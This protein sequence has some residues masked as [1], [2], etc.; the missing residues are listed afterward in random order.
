M[1][2]LHKLS[3][4]K[5]DW[6]KS[7]IPFNYYI[8]GTDLHG[9]DCIDCECGLYRDLATQLHMPYRMASTYGRFGV[10]GIRTNPDVIGYVATN[11]IT[12]GISPSKWPKRGEIS[13]L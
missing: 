10:A 2:T 4:F 6:A 7:L 1:R 5:A 13:E 11:F 3:T 8:S 9:I 12:N